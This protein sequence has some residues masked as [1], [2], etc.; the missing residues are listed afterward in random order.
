MVSCAK[1]STSFLTAGNWG[2]L[3]SLFLFFFCN[4]LVLV[5]NNTKTLS[6]WEVKNEMAGGFSWSGQGRTLK[7]EMGT[8]QNSK[9]LSSMRSFGRLV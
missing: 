6:G 9:T 7:M 1:V 4:R 5:H 3:I 8:G 2:F